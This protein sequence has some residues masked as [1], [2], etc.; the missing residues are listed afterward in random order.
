MVDEEAIGERKRRRK[1][2]ERRV[3]LLSMSG[4]CG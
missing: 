3:M 4:K 1:R 2:R